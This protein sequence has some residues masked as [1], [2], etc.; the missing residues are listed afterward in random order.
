MLVIDQLQNGVLK[1]KTQEFLVRRYMLVIDG[2]L[3]LELYTVVVSNK[4]V[5]NGGGT[6]KHVCQ[7]MGSI[8]SSQLELFV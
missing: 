3:F 6:W 4:L 1:F 7:L 5:L 8:L 2:N